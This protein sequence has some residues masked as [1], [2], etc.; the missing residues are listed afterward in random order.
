LT[1]QLLTF[2]KGGAPIKE[3][4]SI[5]DLIKDSASFSLRGSK[6]GCEQSITDDLWSVEIDK[7]QISQV[8]QNLIINANQAMPDGGIIKIGSENVVIGENNPLPLPEGEYVKISIKDQGN[9]ISEEHL[10]KIFDPY[11]TTK[12]KGS[13]LGL[14]TCYSIIAK[15][16]GHITVESEPGVGTTFFI[17]L[18][19][20][21]K[22]VLVVKEIV[23]E[24]LFYG[25]GKILLMD[26]EQDVID[27]AGQMLIQL[28]YEVEI[29]KNGAE[30]IEL[31][32]K[33]KESGQ[34]FE[35]VILDLTVPGGMGGEDA[36]KKLHERFC[37]SIRNSVSVG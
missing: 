12:E 29:V 13:G 23:E 1:K 3:T 17:Y 31:Y 25:Q 6:V 22:E 11:F 14:A 32:K 27:S 26:D 36:I 21:E 18:P 37:L 19:V 30:A 5:I 20:S 2:A 15:H 34:P 35:A 10:H 16:N 8:I 24:K 4:A 9:G 33:A 28:G 7:G